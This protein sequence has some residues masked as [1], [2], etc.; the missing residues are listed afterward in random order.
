MYGLPFQEIWTG[1]FEFI[2]HA[3]EHP[4]PVCLVAR[5]LLSRRTIRLWQN[6]LGKDPPYPVGRDVLFVSF[7]ADA[8]LSCH[9][10]LGWPLPRHILDL[11]IEF[12]RAI[13]TTPQHPSFKDAT[14]LQALAHYKLD[15]ITAGDKAHWRECI[16]R[17][18]PWTDIEQAGILEYCETDVDG[19]ERLFNAMLACGDIDLS[20]A[21]HRGRYMRA[22]TRMEFLGV[23]IDMERYLWSRDHWEE[24]KNL[25]FE[26][27]G[28]SY[29]VYTE[30]RSFN[31]N[32]FRKYLAE[33]GWGWPTLESGRLELTEKVFKA[34][35]AIHPELEP[36][37]QLRYALEKL[38]LYDLIVSESGFN[39]CWLNPFG[40]RTS[41][42]QPSNARFIFGPAVFLRE[43]LIQPKE[44]YGLSYIDYVGQEVGIAAG[45]SG[46][47]ALKDAYN[48]ADMYLTFGHQAG[49]VPPTATEESH[50]RERDQCKTCFLGTQY[51]IGYQSLAERIDQAEIVA[52]ELL[53]AHRKTYKTYWDWIDN[54]VYRTAI[55]A[56]QS[57]VFGW[58]HRFL[59]VP[60]RNSAR[61]FF[62]QSHGAEMLRHACC[63]GTENGIQINAPIHDAVLITAPVERL[64]T[65][66]ARMQGYME[67]ASRV[68]LG[69][70]T[71]RTQA[72][73][74][75]YPEHY[76]DPKGR[77]GEMLAI[78]TKFYD[79]RTV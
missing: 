5:G 13:N 24:I 3:G 66:T 46:D 69:G 67:E 39:R 76:R 30:E 4:I 10:V 33:R 45:F 65:D 29:G 35:A 2:A 41:R 6:Q 23:P 18:G 64:A 8:E 61:N 15:A 53:R 17:G 75:L 70:F 11:R 63:L 62:M 72:H 60:K 19:N 77:G 31:E 28:K 20:R 71:L 47:L 79:E 22:V 44:G 59:E 50:P 52:R 37:R 21:V 34:M 58:S 16:M 73:S 9:L 48:S 49:V 57:T 54:R 51:G 27:L 32:L 26:A 12:R 40:S 14:F 43:F 74:F 38:K 7:A 56:Q 36:L 25:L 68:I 78:I 42:N 55:S 1:D